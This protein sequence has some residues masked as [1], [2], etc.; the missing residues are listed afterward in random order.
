RIVFISLFSR[1][2]R[3]FTHAQISLVSQKSKSNGTWLCS[4][5][6]I[7]IIRDAFVRSVATSD[8]D[9]A[10]DFG[11]ESLILQQQNLTGTSPLVQYHVKICRTWC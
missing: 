11:L 4:G 2:C 7:I 5:I 9:E 6:K 8:D 1:L 3:C 10:E